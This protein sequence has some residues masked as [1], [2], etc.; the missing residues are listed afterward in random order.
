M[1]TVLKAV[2]E[3]IKE[4]LADFVCGIL[5]NIFKIVAQ[6]TNGLID[7]LALNPE[8]YN[9][10]MWSMLQSVI[11]SA[12]VPI[13]ALV[14]T[15]VMCIELIGWLND[16]NNLNNSS[17]VVAT[18]FK[19][20]IKLFIGVTLVQNAHVITLEIF[21]VANNVI[22]QA[23]GTVNTSV[24]VEMM[25][26]SRMNELK[27]ALMALNIGDL[28]GMILITGIAYL[29]TFVINAAAQIIIIGRVIQIYMY[30][31]IGSVPYATLINKEMSGIG[32]NYLLN[33]AALAFQGFFMVIAI[34]MYGY[35]I[36]DIDLSGMTGGLINMWGMTMY[37][38][39]VIV[40][41]GALV[42]TLIGSKSLSKSIFNAH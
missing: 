12:I 33:L 32:K 26:G 36:S 38:L 17:D 27:E 40:C 37:L 5:E 25:S 29:I 9:A 35:L 16:R 28:F 6:Q 24:A 4:F 2:E 10:S 15:A 3:W 20:V 8:S 34:A 42:F 18:L 22:T 7:D 14:L 39:R 1:D 30:C 23:I 19:Y 41:S 31:S 21:K 13:A 11:R